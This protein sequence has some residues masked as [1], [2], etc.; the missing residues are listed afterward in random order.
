M[1]GFRRRKGAGARKK[2][3]HDSAVWEL[4]LLSS[5]GAGS[6]GALLTLKFR[7]DGLACSH[8][9]VEQ[10][11]PERPERNIRFQGQVDSSARSIEHAHA[12]YELIIG[13]RGRSCALTPVLTRASRGRAGNRMK[14]DGRACEYLTALLSHQLIL[15]R[16]EVRKLCFEYLLARWKSLRP[17]PTGRTRSR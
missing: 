12:G 10:V 7:T 6:K 17:T 13:P 14:V 16:D 4:R 1:D 2:P 3:G 11:R 8:E 9:L 15:M 5:Q